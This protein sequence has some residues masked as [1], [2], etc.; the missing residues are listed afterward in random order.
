MR[1]PENHEEDVNTDEAAREEGQPPCR[2]DADH[3]DR[4]QSLD[5]GPEPGPIDACR[6]DLG[7]I[8]TSQNTGC[9]RRALSHDQSFGSR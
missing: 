4:P 5:V 9:G 8:G 7:N 2:H 6:R 3:R 1:Y